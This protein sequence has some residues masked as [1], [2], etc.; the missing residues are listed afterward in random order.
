VT[1][2]TKLTDQMRLYLA[3]IYHFGHTKGCGFTCTFDGTRK[4]L[5]ARGLVERRVEKRGASTVV[6]F[7]L[8][9]AGAALAKTLPA[10]EHLPSETRSSHGKLLNRLEEVRAG[11]W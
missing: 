7:V 9:P 6:S 8:T 10:P 1:T 2:A 5:V 4:G 11:R 3:A